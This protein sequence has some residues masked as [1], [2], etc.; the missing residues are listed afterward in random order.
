MSDATT[1][2][3][4]P[5]PNFFIVGAPKC[6]TT[7][8]ADFLAQH[9]DVRMGPKELNFFCDDLFLDP[10]RIRSEENYLSH[11][12]DAGDVK[13]HGDG[14]VFY[15]VSG[16]AA[17]RIHDWDADAKI[18]IHVRNPLEFLP[19]HHSQ[20]LFEGF[21][22]LD[23]FEAAYDAEDDRAAGRRMPPKC[24]LRM[25]LEYRRMAAFA[26]QIER[27]QAVFP[28]DQ[29]KIV[30]FDDFKADLPAVYREVLEFLD[31]D[32]GFEAAF[33]VVNPNN[34][35]RNKALMDFMRETPEWVTRLSRIVMSE[36]MRNRLKW[37][38]KRANTEF[39]K[40]EPIS[41]EFRAR[42]RRDIA[43]EVD[44]LGA[45]LDRDLSHWLADKQGASA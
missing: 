38:I 11:Y 1:A 21:E 26:E 37:K 19:S 15:M 7:A 4:P 14:S 29:V 34:R 8:M 44:K 12:A 30:L 33:K 43:P 16:E 5:R 28:P 42:L 18:L 22:D 24:P 31:I 10:A 32:P 9:P 17:R 36:R 23:D 13:V 3:G 6:G 20:I 27:F 2:N 39:V 45:L 40:R 41:P 25:I 35:V